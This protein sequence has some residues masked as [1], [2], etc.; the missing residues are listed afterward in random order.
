MSILYCCEGRKLNNSLSYYRRHCEINNIVLYCTNNDFFA[1]SER[2][3]LNETCK[4]DWKLEN[5][6]NNLIE[7]TITTIDCKVKHAFFILS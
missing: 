1:E 6:E 2:T 7:T 3:T 4:Y 5:R